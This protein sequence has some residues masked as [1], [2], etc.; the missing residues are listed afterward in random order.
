MANRGRPRKPIAEHVLDGTYRSD[1]HGDSPWMPNGEPQMPAWLSPEARELWQ[2]LV[3]SLTTIATE[4]DAASL[5]AMCDW[6]ALYRQ[7]R[8]ALDLVQDRESTAYYK[9]LQLAGLC[10]NNFSGIAAK[11]GLSPSDRAK[12]QV[13]QPQQ[14]GGLADFSRDRNEERRAD[15][16]VDSE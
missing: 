4:V 9:L 1:R 5:T 16:Q 13:P 12:L 15:A 11:F 2:S 14:P 7:T 8:T 10:W 6:W 3:P